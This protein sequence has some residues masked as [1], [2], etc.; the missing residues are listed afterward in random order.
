MS[1][2][3]LDQYGNELASHTDIDHPFEFFI[4]RDPSL[5]IP[6]MS[7]QHVTSSNE[8]RLNQQLFNLYYV[9]I[10]RLDES[11]VSVHLQVDPLL[12]SDVAY[13]VI[14]R[15]DVAPQLN[16][17]INAID[18]WLLLCPGSELF[19]RSNQETGPVPSFR[20]RFDQQSECLYVFH[21]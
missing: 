7:V 16:S 1:L 17:T 19:H 3:I 4:P 15:F 20:R 8:S 21:R 2:S 14:H 9:N 10:T 13:L 5:A 12:N 11:S 18:G 6:A